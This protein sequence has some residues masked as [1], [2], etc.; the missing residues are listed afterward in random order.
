MPKQRNIT[1]RNRHVAKSCAVVT[2][3]NESFVFVR[4]DLA[5]HKRGEFLLC[6]FPDCFLGVRVVHDLIISVF[7]ILSTGD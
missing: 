1:A 4:V 2:L 7:A 5:N 6:L 3:V